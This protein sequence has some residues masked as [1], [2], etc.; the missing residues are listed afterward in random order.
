MTVVKPDITVSNVQCRQLWVI[1]HLGYD[2]GKVELSVRSWRMFFFFIVIF[3]FVCCILEHDVILW[4]DDRP[5]VVN[6]GGCLFPP[7]HA[8]K[9]GQREVCAPHSEDGCGKNVHTKYVNN[10]QLH[11]KVRRAGVRGP[12]IKV[13]YCKIQHSSSKLYP[14]S[15]AVHGLRGACPSCTGD[16]QKLIF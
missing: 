10:A 1:V 16:N 13:G 4:F 11:N 12:F 6:D 9:N 5:R 7:Y 8:F 3:I 2:R 14:T 15:A